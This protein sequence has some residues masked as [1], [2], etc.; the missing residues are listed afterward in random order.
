MKKPEKLDSRDYIIKRWEAALIIALALL[1]VLLLNCCTVT[2][3]SKTENK[4]Q[5]HLIK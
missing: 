2:K 4:F 3:E 1:G 5:I